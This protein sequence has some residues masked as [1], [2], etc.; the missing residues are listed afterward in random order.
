MRSERLHHHL[1]CPGSRLQSLSVHWCLQEAR[2]NCVA[3]EAEKVLLFGQLPPIV[4]MDNTLGTLKAAKHLA[5]SSN[6]IEKITGLK[7]LDVLEVLSLGRNCIKKLEGLDDVANTLTQLWV[8]YNLIDKLNGLEKLT[9]LTVLYMRYAAIGDFF[10][11]A[12]SLSPTLTSNPTADVVARCASNN[13]VAKWTEFEK[14]KDLTKLEELLFVGNPIHEAHKDT[15][16]THQL[17]LVALCVLSTVNFEHVR[18]MLPPASNLVT[19]YVFRHS[20][21]KL[22]NRTTGTKLLAASRGSRNLTEPPLTKKREKQARPS[23]AELV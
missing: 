15:V 22:R 9:N 21:C 13:L 10:A 7:G 17:T 14:F 4:K 12:C 16:C 6:C 11:L 18:S 2:Q 20:N 3:T 19:C 8:S 23:W 1:R 5:L